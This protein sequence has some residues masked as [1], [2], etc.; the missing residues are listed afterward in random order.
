[1]PTPPSR[2]FKSS[3]S[4]QNGGCVEAR[5]TATGLDIRDSKNPAG[6]QLHLRPAA[7]GAFLAE[8]RGR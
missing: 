3:H 8:V 7:W 1:M 5:H 6:P 4:Q 2:W